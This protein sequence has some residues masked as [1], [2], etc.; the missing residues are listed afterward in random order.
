MYMNA[1]Y[2]CTYST[3]RLACRADLSGGDTI[4]P[5]DSLLESDKLWRNVAWSCDSHMTIY[6]HVRWFKGHRTVP[7]NNYIVHKQACVCEDCPVL[8]DVLGT[9]QQY[10]NI[11]VISRRCHWP[12]KCAVW[13]KLRCYACPSYV[14]VL[15]P[16][17]IFLSS[18]YSP[19]PRRSLWTQTN[20][21]L[22][23][24]TQR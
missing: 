18:G 15:M 13:M 23:Q 8:R 19:G 9:S 1:A 24:P 22:I 21:Q 16:V 20:R 7:R 11:F 5:W 2:T 4:E 14:S 6:K 17:Y 10:R 12:S 3:S